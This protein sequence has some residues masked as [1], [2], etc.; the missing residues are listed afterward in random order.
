MVI[1]GRGLGVGWGGASAF[2]SR[3]V[4]THPLGRH[5][6][7][8]QPQGRHPLGT[9]TRADTPWVDNLPG[10]HP[11]PRQTT[12]GRRPQADTSTLP[13]A[14]RETH[15]LPIACWDAHPLPIASWDTP[16]WTEFLTHACKNIT[17]TS[18]LLRAV[19]IKVA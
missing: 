4:C 19:I 2:G 9:P 13:I 3:E 11:I 16:P 17:F 15:P 12:P 6:L 1:S 7:G 5:P 18:L 8:R 10:R 14:C